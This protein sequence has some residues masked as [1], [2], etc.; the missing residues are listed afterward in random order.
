[1]VAP[2]PVLIVS[3]AVSAG[4]GLGRIAGEIAIRADANLKDVCRIASFGY[5]GPGSQ[6]FKFPQYAIEGMADFVLP[7]LP[8]VWADWAGKQAGVILFVWDAGRLGWFSRPNV[9]CEVEPLKQFLTSAKIERWIYNPVDAEGPHDT[10]SYPLVQS[11]LGFDRILA[12]GQWSEDIIRRSLGNEFSQERDL[13]SI[14]H[15]I[16]PAIFCPRD[17]SEA[18]KNFTS[19][20]GCGNLRGT[21]PPPIREDEILIGAVA[22][23][24]ARKDWGLWAEIC[25][26]I[27]HRH[28]PKARFWIHTDKME[29]YWSLFALLVDFGLAD[30]VMFS[31]GYLNDDEMAQAYSACDVTLGIGAGEGFGY[32]IAESLFCGTPCIHGKYAGA[33]DFVDQDL[34]INPVRLHLEGVYNCYR[35]IF[36][37]KDW[38]D[39]IEYFL[40][41]RVNQPS[42]LDWSNVW[43]RFDAWFRKALAKQ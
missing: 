5:G 32:P 23:N 27:L 30:T 15:G 11:L 1:M 38:V 24:Q 42:P 12:Y 21:T 36:D 37:A 3:D 13:G 39:K 28:H 25:E 16:D 6:R 22:T 14:P 26:M 9:M 10:L 7:T 33:V 17:R 4:T 8:E 19:L 35:P 18:R 40:G 31:L 43:P 20:T 41:K 29:N 2:T 34:L